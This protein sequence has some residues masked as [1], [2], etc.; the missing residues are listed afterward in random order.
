[1]RRASYRGSLS[2]PMQRLPK[3]RISTR[4]SI[5]ETIWPASAAASRSWPQ[6]VT[7]RSRK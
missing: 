2:A 4:G 6:T 5:S 7:R 1:M 3:P